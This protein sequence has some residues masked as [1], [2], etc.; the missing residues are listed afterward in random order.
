M[1]EPEIHLFLYRFFQRAG[2]SIG[3]L[4]VSKS[5]HD[6][7]LREE[8]KLQEKSAVRIIRPVNYLETASIQDSVDLE[9][10]SRNISYDSRNVYFSEKIKIF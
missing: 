5:Y 8:I 10:L 3:K 4:I 6:I 1:L 7:V 2:K 9:T